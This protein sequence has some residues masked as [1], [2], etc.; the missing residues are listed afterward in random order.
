MIAWNYA[1]TLILLC[2]AFQLAH[3]FECNGNLCGDSSSCCIDNRCGTKEECEPF[4]VI[5]IPIAAVFVVALVVACVFMVVGK[6]R[7]DRPHQQE[8]LIAAP[9]RATEHPAMREIWRTRGVHR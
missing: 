1:R 5:I 8:P 6:R 9:V 3:G 2:L 7:R 4:Y